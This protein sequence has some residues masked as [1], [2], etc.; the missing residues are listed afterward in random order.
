MARLPPRPNVQRLKKE[1]KTLLR[2]CRKGES[3]ALSRFASIH[4]TKKTK[5]LLA[6][7]QSVVAA[8]Y[9]FDN[10]SELLQ[11]IKEK[12]MARWYSRT[13]FFSKDVKKSLQNYE[14]DFGFTAKWQYDEEGTLVA[15]QVN[16]NGLEI[17]LNLNQQKAGNGL[18]F[19][20]LGNGQVKA[21]AEDLTKAGVEVSYGHWGMPV[22]ILTDLDGN[23]MYFY[24]DEFSPPEE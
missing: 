6:D 7:A 5:I 14:R 8:E 20:S 18:V 9:G 11:F 4:K 24:D 3:K 16:R 19:M 17:I 22:M 10:W 15:A 1:S 2:A 13:V 12:N 21:L 23:E